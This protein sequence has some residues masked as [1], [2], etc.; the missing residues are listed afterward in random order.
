M[1]GIIMEINL[2][3][4]EMILIIKMINSKSYSFNVDDQCKLRKKLLAKR[5]QHEK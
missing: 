3:D 2:S 1:G 4:K 5:R